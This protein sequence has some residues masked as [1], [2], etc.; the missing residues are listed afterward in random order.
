MAIVIKETLTNPRVIPNGSTN[1]VITFQGLTVGVDSADVIVEFIISPFPEVSF[2]GLERVTS[3]YEFT[4]ADNPFSRNVI[5]QNA[6]SPEDNE[7][8]SR[9]TRIVLIA[10]IDHKQGSGMSDSTVIKFV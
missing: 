6:A 9:N 5:I 8:Y 4:T 2:E 3:N 1:V 10:T 7:L